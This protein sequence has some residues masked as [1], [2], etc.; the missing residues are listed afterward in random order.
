MT[1]GSIGSSFSGLGGLTPR[2]VAG[3]PSDSPLT[4][5]ASTD[6]TLRLAVRTDD[7]D[8]VTLTAHRSVDATL[9]TYG[10]DGGFRFNGSSTSEIG[11][12][13]EGELDRREVRDLRHLIHR[14]ERVVASF[15]KGHEAAMTHQADRLTHLGS[16][17]SFQFEMDR[18]RTVSLTPGVTTPAPEPIEDPVAVPAATS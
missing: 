16:L 9:A 13:V 17:E 11:I 2:L 1:I 5:A 8:T 15:L 14:I 7:G 12:T 10:P 4:L 3:A 18:S 6:T